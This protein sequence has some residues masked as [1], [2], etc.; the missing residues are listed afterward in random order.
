MG[1]SV[2]KGRQSRQ[3][4]MSNFVTE[5]MDT[6]PIPSLKNFRLRRSPE[7]TQAVATLKARQ[8]HIQ[9]ISWWLTSTWLQGR[10]TFAYSNK[11]I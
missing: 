5:K 11:L 9:E 1:K 4:K 2:T 8:L 7:T 10:T 3:L 6:F